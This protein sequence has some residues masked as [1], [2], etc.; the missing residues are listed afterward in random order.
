M[1]Q[2]II[3]KR[4]DEPPHLLLWRMDEIAPFMVGL[5]VGILIQQLFLCLVCGVAV[6]KVY[7]KIRDSHPDGFFM[8]WITWNTGITVKKCR[9]IINPF[10]KRL[11]P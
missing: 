10:I 8:H 2:V 6:S 1:S 5:V 7:I 9:T 3:P 4:I 11:F